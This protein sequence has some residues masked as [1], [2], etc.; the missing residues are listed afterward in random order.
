MHFFYASGITQQRRGL[1]I[2]I[3][4]QFRCQSIVTTGVSPISDVGLWNVSHKMLHT[5][6]SIVWVKCIIKE[7]LWR[8]AKMWVA[9]SGSMYIPLS[10][11]G[12]LLL[13]PPPNG[14][15]YV[16][17]S[18]GLFV[19]LSSSNITENAWTGRWNLVQGTIWNNFGMFH[20]TP[21]TQGIFFFDI[22]GD[23]RVC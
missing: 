3:S 5:L 18:V 1:P 13:L 14:E 4:G 11:W 20:L 23:I 19:C 17:I 9:I 15:G 2:G 6:L 7:A 21:W 10:H 22:F 8:R 16:F 12:I